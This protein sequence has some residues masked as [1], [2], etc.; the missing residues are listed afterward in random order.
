MEHLRGHSLKRLLAPAM[1]EN[2]PP[3]LPAA[4]GVGVD[5]LS[6]LSVMH[7]ARDHDGAPRPILHRDVKPENVIIT[8]GG[9]PVL[10]DFGIA[11]DVMGPAITLYGK[12]VGTARYMAPE[13]RLGGL[14]DPRADVFSLS[15]ILFELISARQPWPP[16]STRKELLR[17][18]FDPPEITSQIAER[19]PQD[20]L[21]IVIK[22]LACDAADRWSDAGE[23]LEALRATETYRRLAPDGGSLWGEISRWVESTGLTPD[24]ALEHLVIDHRA[25][26]EG[27]EELTW[28]PDGQLLK[29]SGHAEVR[30]GDLP[31]AEVL[32]IPPLAPRR[33]QSIQPLEI[34]DLADDDPSELGGRFKWL[35]ASGIAVLLAAAAAFGFYLTHGAH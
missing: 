1:A 21:P 19:I 11:K 6:A 30:A 17:I 2:R 32:T 16:L 31:P 35:V 25:A 7:G 34:P 20:V 18:V 28:S 10:I 3:S 24:E 5:L 22:G 33:D 29:I 14:L 23:M 8:H 27:G 9:K 12:V 4:L 13:N 15:L 26:H